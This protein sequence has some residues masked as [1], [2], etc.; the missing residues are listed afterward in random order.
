MQ[1]HIGK[2]IRE[3]IKLSGKKNVDVAKK[4]DITPQQLNRWK[5]MGSIKS[6]WVEKFANEFGMDIK[7][8][9]DLGNQHETTE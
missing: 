4:L 6:E 9:L 1:Y 2:S 8:F 3:A 5:A 7:R